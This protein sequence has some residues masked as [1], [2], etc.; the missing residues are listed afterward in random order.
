MGTINTGETYT[1]L[2]STLQ[3]ICD[4]VKSKTGESSV[5]VNELANDI[6]N[7]G[8]KPLD[9]PND[10]IFVDYDGTII[11]EYDLAEY[12]K[13]AAATSQSYN[14]YYVPTPPTH[15]GLT[16]EGWNLEN[17][18]DIGTYVTKLGCAII[19]ANYHTTDDKTHLYITIED[20]SELSLMLT[21]YH[22]TTGYTSTIDWGDG[23]T[24][25]VATGSGKKQTTHT[26]SALGSYVIK[27][28]PS[29]TGT[30]KIRLGY[31]SGVRLLTQNPSFNSSYQY[32]PA[33][34]CVR[35]LEMSS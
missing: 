24:S 8:S 26:Y 31:S 13:K 15:T 33:L 23:T 22:S 35:A 21:Y 7:I 9:C 18:T 34:N 5:N 29:T 25:E 28:Y 11:E 14:T 1:I 32:G 17:D 4:A 16:F 3:D 10:I 27:F 6:R 20:E 19:G 30:D 12:K 2:G